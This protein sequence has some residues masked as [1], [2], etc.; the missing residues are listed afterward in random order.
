[1]KSGPHLHFGRYVVRALALALVVVS[2]A[3]FAQAMGPGAYFGAGFG[4]SKMNDAST[5][6]LGTTLDDRDTAVKFFGGYMFNPYFGL[7]LG[8]IEFGE[9]AGAFPSEEWRASGVDF[10]LVGAVPL[11]DRYSNFSLFGKVGVNAW[12]VDDD[13][14]PFGFASDSGTDLSYG[15]GAEIEF[16]PEFGANI[17]WERF[18]DVGNPNV[19]GRSDIDM[20]T[21]NFVYH[22]RPI[23][24][25]YPPVRPGRYPR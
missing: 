21:I 16:N 9:F 22:L 24:Y 12:S 25:S 4:Q 2:G 13:V 18:T 23:V 6:L 1:M 19:T 7:E 14:F 10:S 17:Q 15:I 11:P 3:A 5:T 20:F 8:F